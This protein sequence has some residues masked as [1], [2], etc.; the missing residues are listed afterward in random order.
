MN[1]F[2]IG[3]NGRTG[4]QLV[5]LALARGHHVTAF[6]RAASRITRQHQ[7]LRVAVGDPLQTDA[8]AAALP[9]H[10]V[11]FSALGVAPG[12]L[13][14]K[15]TLLQHCA[16]STVAAMTRAGVCRLSLVSAATLFEGSGPMVALVRFILQRQVRDLEA[17]EAIVRA[18]DLEWT[19]ARPPSLTP[20]SS[21]RWRAEVDRLPRGAFSMTFRAVAAFLLQAAEAHTHVRQIVGLAS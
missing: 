9:G 7:R 2:V 4:T 5:D 14:G 6:V 10:D 8:L 1:L 11:V 15:I 19:F 18:S 3:A 12:A 13:L 20:G 17:A 16:A 21:E